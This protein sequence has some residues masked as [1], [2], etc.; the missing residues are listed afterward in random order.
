MKIMRN[1]V[2]FDTTKELEELIKIRE[3]LTKYINQIDDRN[4]IK[5]QL[6]KRDMK[7]IINGE[8]NG[9]K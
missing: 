2:V 1:G 3:E 4:S 8:N 6:I 9:Q 5:L 7:K